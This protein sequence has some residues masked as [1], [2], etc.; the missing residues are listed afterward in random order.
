METPL[1]ARHTFCMRGASRRGSEQTSCCC[2]AE[3]LEQ[4]QA[5]LKCLEQEW[6][7]RCRQVV[8]GEIGLFGLFGQAARRDPRHIVACLIR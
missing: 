1:G 5:S 6:A 4:K 2:G 8:R 3:L 7:S